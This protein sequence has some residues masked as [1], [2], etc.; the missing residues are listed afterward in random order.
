MECGRSSFCSSSPFRS[1]GMCIS[2][3]RSGT[4]RRQPEARQ[5]LHRRGGQDRRAQIKSEAGEQHDAAEE[6]H[7]LGIVQPVTAPSRTRPRCP[8]SPRTWRR[9]RFN[10]SIDE[11]PADLKEFGLAE[12]RVEVAF[13]AGGQEQ[14]P[15]DR[16]EDAAGQRP[17]R[18]ARRPEEG[19]PD[20]LVPRLDLQSRHVRPARQVGP[21]SIATKVDALEV[22]AA[23]RTTALRRSRT[24]N[25]S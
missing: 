24:A 8:A 4:G 17:L 13:K 1:A 25:G 3:N 20:R 23:G 14:P 5:A 11:N 19:L 12:P 7:R 16:A 18:Q 21:E 2:S 10:A 9:S 6:G 22:T 15:P